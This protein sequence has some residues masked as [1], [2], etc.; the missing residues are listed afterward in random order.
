MYAV[1]VSYEVYK[2]EPVVVT[3]PVEV[4]HEVVMV[5]VVGE[6]EVLDD[7]LFV[8]VVEEDEEEP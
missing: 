1:I 3:Q 7:L 8:V 6:A 4:V 5:G 2:D